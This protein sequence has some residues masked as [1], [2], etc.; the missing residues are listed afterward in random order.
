MVSMIDKTGDLRSDKDLQEAIKV[1][2]ELMRN[3]PMTLPR[4]VV[5]LPN[6]RELLLELQLRRKGGD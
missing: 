5:N 1:I 4:L 3:P 2:E 6:I